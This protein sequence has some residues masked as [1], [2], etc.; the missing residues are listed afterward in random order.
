LVQ[1]EREQREKGCDR[2]QYDDVNNNN[3]NNNIKN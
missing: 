2:R 1:G 3:N